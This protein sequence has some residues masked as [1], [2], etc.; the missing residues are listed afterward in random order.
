M[1]PVAKR[2]LY[3]QALLANSGATRKPRRNCVEDV[4]IYTKVDLT[5]LLFIGRIYRT[6]FTQR[7]GDTSDGE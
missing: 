4:I 6:D 5:V 2:R 7:K 1:E 3:T